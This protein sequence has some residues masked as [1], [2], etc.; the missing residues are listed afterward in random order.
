MEQA[1]TESV[2]IRDA[3]LAGGRL[4]HCVNADQTIRLMLKK[5]NQA[6]KMYVLCC[7]NPNG[8]KTEQAS[9]PRSGEQLSKTS[10]K[11]WPGM[12]G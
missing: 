8:M 7:L 12:I 9:Q 2:I 11:T 10:R 1:G 5:K 3:G 6:Q 4:T